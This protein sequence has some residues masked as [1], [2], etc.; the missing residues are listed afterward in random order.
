MLV[1][2][3]KRDEAL[4]FPSLGIEVRVLEIRWDRVR[5]GIDAPANVRVLRDELLDDDVTEE[6]DA[7]TDL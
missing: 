6:T 7:G 4:V 2:S 1:L 5:I 3:R